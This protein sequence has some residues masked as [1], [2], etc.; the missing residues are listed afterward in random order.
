MPAWLEPNG[1]LNYRQV[2]EI[3]AWLTASSDVEFEHVPEHAEAAA[4]PAPS[5]V[6]VRG[7]RDPNFTPAPDAT[8]VPACWRNPTGQIGGGGGG[9]QP[10]AAPID[11]PGTADNPR[12]IKLDETASLTITDPAGNK[13]TSIAVAPG[14]T[15][16][17]EVTNSAGYDHNFYIG[18]PADLEG[19]NV[20]NAV[21][22]PAFAS[23]TK[24][25]TYTV[26]E[27]ISSPLEFACT[28]PG[29][30]AT[31]HGEIT[32]QGGGGDGAVTTPQPAASPAA[33]SDA[34]SP[35]S[36]PSTSSP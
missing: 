24:T 3:I 25:V 20:A 1:P 23:G 12:V 21:G 35:T 7:W 6:T 28:L 16:N 33:S 14:E 11:Q 30:Y 8:P 2:E 17:F 15:V 31:M 32:L 13:V 4:G 19:N 22:V 10:S 29:H 36:S 34:S 27:S 9:G 5:P 18:S 26:P